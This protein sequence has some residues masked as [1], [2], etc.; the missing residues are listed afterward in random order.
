MD[1]IKF[2]ERTINLAKKSQG[3][4]APRPA[5]G[6]LLVKDGKIIS[7]GYT[8]PR[9][10]LHAEADAINNAKEDIKGST[11]FC[12]LE[13]HN[14]TTHDTPC[15]EKIINSGITKV[16]CPKIDIN[17]KVNGKGFEDLKNKGI[18][19]ENNWGDEQ[20]KEINNLYEGYEFNLKHNRPRVS[21]KF[22]MTLDGKISTKNGDSKWIT[23]EQ[24]RNKVH[25]IRYLSDA[26]IT[27][28]NTIIEDNA[29]LT[30]REKN[31]PTGK[32][33]YRVILD[34]NSKLN[35]SYKIFRDESLGEVIWFTSKDSSPKKIPQHISHK[36]SKFAKI[37]PKEVLEH[38]G[39]IGC[40]DIL[41]ES[42]GTLLGSFFDQ[43]IVDKVYAFIA[44]SIFGG[45]TAPSPVEGKGIDKIIDRINL[46]NVSIE[47]IE[48]DILITG[49]IN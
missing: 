29:I 49:I 34:N 8:K 35:E 2:Q 45:Q 32:P 39:E 37:D 36:S 22:A 42:G 24:S 20:V 23:S 6:A 48:E 44:P 18:I 4:V 25:E 26:I 15:T 28:I 43:K 10:G 11:L 12:T 40:L 3:M 27:G 46:K 16:S 1:E 41:I 33:K 38:L 19:V 17:P 31:K 7:E 21:A 47:S 14:F 30:A 13:P 5:V 9:P